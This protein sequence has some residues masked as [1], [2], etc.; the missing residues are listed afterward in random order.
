MYSFQSANQGCHA[1]SLRVP[2]VVASF[3]PRKTHVFCRVSAIER[4]SAISIAPARLSP[5]D[6]KLANLRRDY[7][8]LAFQPRSKFIRRLLRL[9]R[10]GRRKIM[11]GLT[12]WS[13]FR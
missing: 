10:A 13:I 9:L 5:R 1:G 8:A 6:P 2:K 3:S 7:R 12:A 4:V 11:L